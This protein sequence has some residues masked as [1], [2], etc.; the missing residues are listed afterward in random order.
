MVRCQN[1][2]ILTVQLRG[3][4]RNANVFL[5]EQ[6]AEFSPTFL[7][8]A[9]Q[10]QIRIHNNDDT[11]V[12][13]HWTRFATNT[14]EHLERSRRLSEFTATSSSTTTATN[15]SSVDSVSN[16]VSLRDVKKMKSDIELDRLF[17]END[18][19]FTVYP[20]SGEIMPHSSAWIY[21]DFHPPRDERFERVIFCDV[22]GRETRLPLKL[23]GTGRGPDVSFT[24]TDLE[25][26]DIFVNSLHEYELKM[27][28]HGIIPA[29]FEIAMPKSLFGTKFSFVP[30]SGVIEP[31]SSKDIVVRFES[32]II[33]EFSEWFRWKIEGRKEALMVNAVGR[34][35][36]PSFQFD[37]DAVDFGTVAYSFI[38]S[39]SITLTNTSEIPMI[40]KLKIPE[41]GQLLK[42]EFNI[43]PSTGTIL[44]H[45]SSEV[46]YDFI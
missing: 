13:F 14:D 31:A 39:R 16:D 35:V 18:D 27:E 42:R 24:F 28:N 2:E 25:V 43:L 23:V 44:P 3:R 45:T 10:R 11:K 34:V 7:Q 30:T 12:C 19:V 5:S 38:S 4:A 8:N 9:S 6:T 37:V 20:V 29:R 17:F 1:G 21:I 26:G 40:F 33:G 41:D 22:Q 36:G 15:V 46:R 32:D